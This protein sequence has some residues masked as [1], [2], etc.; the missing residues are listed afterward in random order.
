MQKVNVIHA[1]L[2]MNNCNL[3]AHLYKIHVVDSPA[4]ACLCSQSI[5]GTAYFFLDCPLYF[6]QRIS[7]QNVSRFTEFKLETLLF[8]G[9]N[10]GYVVNI[11]IRLAM[12]EYRISPFE[13]RL[14]NERL[15]L[16]EH[17]VKRGHYD[18]RHSKKMNLKS[19]IIISV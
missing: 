15:V 13:R 6:T 1:Q 19:T 16:N 5:D 18:H 2:R 17:R 7:L 3:N 12:H 11:T 14:S 8:E 4:A 10:I 9:R